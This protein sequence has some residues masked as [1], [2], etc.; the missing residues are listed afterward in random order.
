MQAVSSSFTK[1]SP[2]LRFII[3]HG[4]GAAPYHWGRFKG[5]AKKKGREFAGLMQNVYFDTCFYH[6]P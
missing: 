2:D 1:G 5:M 4:A 3:P 6:Q